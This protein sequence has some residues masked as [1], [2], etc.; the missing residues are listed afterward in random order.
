MLNPV[1]EINKGFNFR[2]HL[3]HTISK[4]VK[5]V[6]APTW[7]KDIIRT[8]LWEFLKM[9]TKKFCQIRKIVLMKSSLFVVPGWSI[10]LLFYA[11]SYRH[12]DKVVIM[13]V[14][15]R[16]LWKNHIIYNYMIFCLGTIFPLYKL[17]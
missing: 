12:G 16:I 13:F 3:T 1:A 10:I 11:Q 4:V 6:K 2:G 14:F 15:G 9:K 5:P 17:C 7:K 8:N